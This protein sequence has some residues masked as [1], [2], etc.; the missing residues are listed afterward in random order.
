MTFNKLFAA[1]ALTAMLGAGAAQARTVGGVTF[2]DTVQQAGQTLELNGIGKRVFALIVDGYASALYVPKPAHT[3]EAILAEPGPKLL[4]T[5]FLHAASVNQIRNEYKSVYNSYCSNHACSA[6]SKQT[7]DKIL[8]SVQPVK[9]GDT[10]SY[11]ID[12]GNLTLSING[13]T[14]VTAHDPEYV[15]GMLDSLLGA[16]SPTAGYRNGLLGNN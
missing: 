13:R 10:A 4:Y 9:S 5:Q 7:F 14:V 16:A 3:A 11:L 12:D 1:L 8:A 6:A 15:H 2:P